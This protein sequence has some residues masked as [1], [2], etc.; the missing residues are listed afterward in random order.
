MADNTKTFVDS[1]DANGL[2]TGFKK[3]LPLLNVP[4]NSPFRLSAALV[5]GIGVFAGSKYATKKW[6]GF[7][8]NLYHTLQKV[9]ERSPNRIFK[10]F[11]LSQ[12]QS[13][14]LVDD[15]FLKPESLVFGD[16]LTPMGAHIQRLLGIDPRDREF[17]EGLTFKRTKPTSPYLELQ[18][19][20]GYSIR[21]AERGRLAASSAR[22]GADLKEEVKIRS[23][24]E[25]W[26]DLIP[27]IWKQ[28]REGTYLRNPITKGSSF[29][30]AFGGESKYFQPLLG[31]RP[32]IIGGAQSVVDTASRIAFD[33]A[34][35]PLRLLGDIGLGLRS[36]SYNKLFHIPGIGSGGLLNELFTK[37]VIPAYLGV[38]ALRYINYK[39]NNKPEEAVA[40]LPLKLNLLRAQLTDTIPGARKVT[41]FYESVVPG[42]QYG[43]LAIP[44]AGA[45]IGGFAH[46]AGVA[47]GIKQFESFPVRRAAFRK[48]AIAGALIGG[49]LALPFLPGMLG[50]RKTAPELERIYSGEEDVPIR[51]GR[52]WEIGSTPFQGGRIKYYRPHWYSLMQTKP[53]MV[54]TYGS[55]EEYW[56]HHPLLHPIKYLRDPY[57]LEKKNYEDRPYPITSPAFSNVPLIGTFL[58]ATIGKIVKPPVRMH[59]GEWDDSDYTLYSP[60]LEPKGPVIESKLEA[61]VLQNLAKH[62]YLATTQE[63]EGKYRLDFVVSGDN[64][65]RL[66]IESEGF[67]YHHTKHQLSGDKEREAYLKSKGWDIIHVK[68]RPF[69]ADPDKAMEDVYDRLSDLKINPIKIE[70]RDINTGLYGL[71]PS[72][73]RE[74]FSFKD[75]IK[76]EAL[77]FAEFTGLPGFIATTIYGEVGPQE[78]PGKDVILQGSRQMT[79]LSSSYYQREL[80]AGMAPI[81]GEVAPF[82]YTEPLRRF[83]QPERLL[84]QANEIPNTMPKWLPGEDYMINFRTGDPYVK[85]PEGGARLPGAGYASVHPELQGLRPDQYP[86]IYRYKILADVAPYSKEYMMY[87][88]KIRKESEKDSRL[89]IEFARTEEQVRQMKES[90]VQFDKRRFTEPVERLTGTIK[91]A[92]LEGVELEEFPGKTFQFSSVGLSAADLSAI[93][94]GQHN[95]F[96]ANQVVEEVEH[97]QQD[98]LHYLQDRV[99]TSVSVVVPQGAGTHGT[100]ARAVIFDGDVNINKEMVDRGL[101]RMREDLSGSEAQAMY[102]QFGRALGKYA[103]TL[104]FQGEGGP[105]RLLPTPYHTKLW[106]ERTAIAQYQEQEVYGTRMRRW[107]HPIHDMIGPWTRGLWKRISGEAVISDQAQH[108]RELDSLSDELAYLRGY[109]QADVHP[110]AKGRY[111]SQ[112]KRTN[113][114]GNLF[115]NPQFVS[116]TLPRR[117]RLYFSAFLQETDPE[118]RVQILKSVTPEM[119]R[120]L[121]A[122]W[123]KQ[124]TDLAKAAGKDTPPI[125]EG[126][127][128]FTKENLEE[129]KNAKTSLSYGD[130]V[131]SKQ[132]AETFSTLGFNLPGADSPLWF[133]GLD[134]EDVKLKIVQNEGYDYHDFNIY[135]DRAALLWRKPYVD[136][137]VRE[138]TSG[139]SPQTAE[140]IRQTVERII[141]EGQDKNPAVTSSTQASRTGGSNVTINIDEQGDKAIMRDIRRNS[142]EYRN[143][144]VN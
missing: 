106:Q 37:R 110:T 47:S 30:Q 83:I 87:K 6:P 108:N 44:I 137:A 127:I 79:N 25:G 84:A 86:D 80:G 56:A 138:L 50:S 121:T 46:W 45:V 112:S 31:R 102:G 32:G 41:D 117:E 101:A 113:I 28:R 9:E 99:G 93:A 130:F 71:A 124:D 65:K 23:F 57:W 8:E 109:M 111:T 116:T 49:V 43:P 58:A 76:R 17:A 53:E 20:P 63:P 98:L 91:R 96:T 120:A 68:S 61:M 122:Q 126:G 60:R 73:P 97:K 118:K 12:W 38:T 15:V 123:V 62:G 48:S 5:A 1:N 100:E 78:T 136:G 33:A 34:E 92:T 115:G 88:A 81:P 22:Y 59:E 10:T 144:S 114:G 89:A 143:D 72:T 55:Q 24:A 74:E 18:G 139:G 107:Q 11:S 141:Q 142:D 132:I 26:K 19:K 7:A 133:E 16:S 52:W 103:E 90:T 36:G 39:L 77:T 104:S 128:L 95:D 82:G 42:P 64:G 14:H 54:A 2:S 13:S 27:S 134:Y 85:V 3:P 67:S 70:G 129:Y 105:L 119:S 4:Q 40:G 94:L 131:R 35:R 75:V 135:D 125:E 140:R 29:G 69:F 66:A 51:A 21:F